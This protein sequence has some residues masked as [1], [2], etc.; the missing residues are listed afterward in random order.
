[1][2]ESASFRNKIRREKPAGREIERHVDF[3]S[4]LCQLN[5]RARSTL[6]LWD[7]QFGT[8]QRRLAHEIRISNHARRL[9]FGRIAADE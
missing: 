1:M 9:L 8:D 3:R 2:N 6:S 7:L 5:Y 4:T